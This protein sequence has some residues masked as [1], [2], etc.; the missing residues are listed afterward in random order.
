[1]NIDIK[2]TPREFAVGI[3]SE[4]VLKDCA[5][6]YL[7]PNEQVTF[8]TNDKKEYDVCYKDWGFYATPSI[9]GRLSNYGFKTAL[10][11]SENKRRYI[12]LVEKEKEDLFNQYLNKEN[13]RIIQWLDDVANNNICLCGMNDFEFVYRYLEPPSGEMPYDLQNQTYQRDLIKCI[14]CGHLLLIHDYNLENIYNGQYVQSTYMDKLIQTFNKIINLPIEKSDN[15]KR[16]EN[17]IRFCEEYFKDISISVLD[18]GSGLCVFLYLLSQ[19]TTWS[20]RALDPDP[21]QAKHAQQI[22]NIPSICCDFFSLKSEDKFHVI[23][24]N[25]VLEHVK[26]PVQMLRAAKKHLVDQGVVYIELPDGTAALKDSVLREEFF[27]EHYHAFSMQSLTL[28]IEKAGFIPL[29]L[30]RLKEPSGK[31]TLRAFC[32]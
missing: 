9:N 30:E 27:I 4:I 19:K 18:V 15:Y 31:Y 29:H 20:L 13:H 21:L 24:F 17:I 3:N 5:S 2:N 26:D 22:C 7:K 25:K 16:V 1:M 14:Y 10:V 32:S 23:T 6:I 28:L 11:E 12:W 8:I